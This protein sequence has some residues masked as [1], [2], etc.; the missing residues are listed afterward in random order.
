[1]DL[2]T[3]TAKF[4]NIKVEEVNH[5]TQLLDITKT[6]FLHVLGGAIMLTVFDLVY[7]KLQEIF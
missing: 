2:P 4:L 7:G 6:V 1:M 5:S 3:A